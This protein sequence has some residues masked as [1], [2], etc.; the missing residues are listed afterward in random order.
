MA[1]GKSV[2]DNAYAPVALTPLPQ[3]EQK[4]D[5]MEVQTALPLWVGGKAAAGL[6]L[7][8]LCQSQHGQCSFA[9]DT[10][11][12]ALTGRLQGKCTRAV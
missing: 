8:F 7:S 12:P 6:E 4:Q 2:G 11:L 1:N 5:E 10:P 9:A 3:E